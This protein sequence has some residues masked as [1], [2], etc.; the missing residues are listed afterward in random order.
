[1]RMIAMITPNTMPSAI[2]STAM[3]MVL[4]KPHM[5]A[6]EVRNWPM[7]DHSICPAKARTISA[8][9]ST[10]AA[11]RKCGRNAAR[12]ELEMADLVDVGRHD[13]ASFSV[14]AI[15]FA[16]RAGSSAEPRRERRERRVEAL[17]L[18][19]HLAGAVPP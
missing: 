15:S 16:V 5:I 7:Y 10:T 4:S 18:L 12:H 2:A 17:D 13:P 14:I 19:A 1:M 8:R 6:W 9:T 11:R 3:T